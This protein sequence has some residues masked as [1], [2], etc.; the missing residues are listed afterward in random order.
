L[1][2]QNG[3][4]DKWELTTLDKVVSPLRISVHPTDR[5]ELPYIGMEHVEPET[6]RLVSTGSA[7]EMKSNARLFRPGDVLYGRL[8]PYLNKVYRPNFEGLCSA[9]FIVFP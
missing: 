1:S 8:R 4:S 6:M 2:E 3:L 5:P 9:E 7:E